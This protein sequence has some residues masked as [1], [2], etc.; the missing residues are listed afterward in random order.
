MITININ[1]LTDVQR[2]LSR[3]GNSQIP[4]AT[5]RALTQ[6][7]KDAQPAIR[8]GMQR[9]FDRPTPYT[10]NSTRTDPATKTKPQASVE[11]RDKS[12]QRTASRKSWIAP[13]VYGG[14]RNLKNF[15]FLLRKKGILPARMYA[16]P[17]AGADLDAFGNMTRGQ[18]AQLLA[19]FQSFTDQGYKA[20][21]T[22][23]G[24]RAIDR[25]LGKKAAGAKVQYIVSAGRSNLSTMHLAPGIYK[26]I[27]FAAGSSLKPILM[28]VRRPTYAPALPF[29]QIVA[30]VADEKLIPNFKT[31]F[32][33]ALR[34]A[35]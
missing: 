33:E 6:T 29:N 22:D 12:A 20:N 11:L 16:V 18:I 17:G 25:R 1:G 14:G 24:R 21:S 30:E 31:A 23:K 9:T 27:G 4:Y 15:E 34:T 19:Y 8:S 7:A 26:R 3:L 28:F 32:A 10:L 13:Q 5:A 2:K 35:K